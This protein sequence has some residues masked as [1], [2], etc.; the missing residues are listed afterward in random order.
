MN[1]EA[2][3][4]IG[5]SAVRGGAQLGWQLTALYAFI[6]LAAVILRSSVTIIEFPPERGTLGLLL[7]NALCLAWAV[8]VSAIVG[9][10]A[11]MALGMATGFLLE[12][13]IKKMRPGEPAFQGAL[14]GFFV[15]CLILLVIQLFPYIW[16]KPQVQN[17]P[18]AT[19]WF[20]FVNPDIF[21]LLSGSMA[22]WVIQKRRNAVL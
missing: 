14:A 19:L 13:M 9:G 2:R 7:A 5:G 6:F 3:K 11:A 15:S 12:K 16:W 20:W 21:Y 1:N 10:V 17:I 4:P 18:P 8:S 22:G